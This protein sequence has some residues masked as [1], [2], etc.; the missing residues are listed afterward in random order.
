[1]LTPSGVSVCCCQGDG[2]ND[3]KYLQS[4]QLFDIDTESRSGVEDNRVETINEVNEVNEFDT[5]ASVIERD[6]PTGKASTTTRCSVLLYIC[7][8]CAVRIVY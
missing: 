6:P 3:V 5:D 7:L 1:M 8:L 2:C 4:C